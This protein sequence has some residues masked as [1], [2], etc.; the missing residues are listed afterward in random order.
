[1]TDV[2]VQVPR[3]LR[4]K[5]V[6]KLTGIAPWRIYELIARGKGPAHMRVGKTIRVSL[7][8]LVKWID[9]QSNNNKVAAA[10]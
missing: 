4:I 3:L 5:E 7:F 2:L 8:A 6:A 10:K 1:M 9:E